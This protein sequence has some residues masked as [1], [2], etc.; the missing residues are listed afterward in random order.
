MTTL[1]SLSW[2]NIWRHPARSGV[3]LAAVVAGLWA[4]VFTI[5]AYKGMLQQRMDYLIN[6]EIT[7]AQVHHPEFLSEGYSRMFLPEHD[8]ILA[9][10]DLD[11]RVRSHTART[12]TSGMLQSPA[13]TNG[14]RIKGILVESETRTTTLHQKLVEGD[15]LDADVQNALIMS[16]S[17]AETHNLDQYH[18]V[19]LT[20]EDA[21]SELVSAAF[22]IVGFFESASESFDRGNVFVRSQDLAKLLA[23]RT[24]YHEIAMML[25]DQG[26]AAAVVA[27]LNAGF[28]GISAQTWFELSP[29]LRTMLDYGGVMLFIITIVIMLALAF[30]ILN[31]MLMGIFERLREIGMLLSVGM[32]RSRIFIMILLESIILT[33]IGALGG[34]LMAL[35]SIAYFSETGINLE[36]FAEGIAEIGWEHIVYPV[37][38]PSEFATIAMIVVAVTLLASIYPAIKAIRVN[39][40]EAA[41]DN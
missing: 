7:H 40:I 8:R 25:H 34:I 35:L 9:W 28:S 15:Y 29:E 5:G 2:R 22:H 20:F 32:S 39:P 31:T 21:E 17:L 4:G 14:V 18:R 10:L 33:L 36:I 27:D 13:R 23:G 30:G 37:M 1:L 38:H 41:K 11:P 3:L 19:V 16:R 26:D 6:S 12:I 24:I